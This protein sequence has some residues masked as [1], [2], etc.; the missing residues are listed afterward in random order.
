MTWLAMDRR[1][2]TTP[3]LLKDHSHNGLQRSSHSFKEFLHFARTGSKSQRTRRNVVEELLGSYRLN[4]WVFA[5]P[6]A[7]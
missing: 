7:H 1:E 6:S 4:L 5:H 2:T 3:E